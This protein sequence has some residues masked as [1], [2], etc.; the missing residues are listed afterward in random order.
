MVIFT[1]HTVLICTRCFTSLYLVLVY[2]V[3]WVQKKSMSFYV[4][5]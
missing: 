1:Q 4:D 5:I 3:C 2:V